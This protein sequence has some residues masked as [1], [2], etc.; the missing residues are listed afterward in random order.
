MDKAWI[1]EVIGIA[2]KHDLDALEVEDK[3]GTVR[4]VRRSGSAPA[5]PVAVASPAQSA[6]AAPARGA[7]SADFAGKEVVK[8]HMVGIFSTGGGE[9]GAS[10]PSVGE[11]VS[12]GQVLGFVEAMKM[13]SEVTAHC[14]G[15]LEEVLVA[16]GQ[17]VQYGDPLF[18]LRPGSGAPEGGD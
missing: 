7:A 8:C 5:V 3:D 11:R 10:T 1:E 4:V 12:E 14:A 2:E 9:G 18:L 17:S 13:S 15:V 16:D 6:A